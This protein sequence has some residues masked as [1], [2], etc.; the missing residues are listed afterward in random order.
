MQNK[1]MNIQYFLVLSALYFQLTDE[2]T[3]AI[4]DESML[5]LVESINEY[6]PAITPELPMSKIL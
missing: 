2:Q 3:V 1:Y 6:I 4:N 5:E